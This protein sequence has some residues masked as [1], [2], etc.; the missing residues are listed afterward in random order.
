MGF[1]VNVRLDGDKELMRALASVT[2]REQEVVVK[3]ATNRSMRPVVKEARRNAP[4]ETGL[5]RKSIGARTKWYRKGA[6]RG[7][8]V[9]VTVVGPR[10]GFKVDGRNPAMY[11][12]LVHG[13]TQPHEIVPGEAR[14]L[15]VGGVT[16]MA[17]QHPGAKPNPFL[18]D[19]FDKSVGEVE[20]RFK[21]MMF[22]QI[23]AAIRRRTKK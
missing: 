19:A 22:Q 18:G 9:A 17:V 2:G 14:A 3:R 15:T 1:G 12:H 4:V 8:G 21:S 6:E 16:I 5:L 23:E 11:A 7:S 13:G 20:R 10:K